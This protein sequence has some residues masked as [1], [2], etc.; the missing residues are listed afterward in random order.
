[1]GRDALVT[2]NR[3]LSHRPTPAQHS[4]VLANPGWIRLT[5]RV[6]MFLVGPL[7]L[8]LT[9]SSRSPLPPAA[10]VIAAIVGIGTFG[11]AVWQRPWNG[12]ELFIAD[13][14]GVTFP[15]NDHVRIQIGKA[16]D[17]RWLCVPW[18][19][20]HDI[21]TAKVRGD[22]TSCVAFDVEVTPVEMNDFF[23]NVGEPSDRASPSGTMVHAAF[24]I[25]PP[26]PAKT[27]AALLALRSRSEA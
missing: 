3:V 7:L 10:L 1:V 6:L 15:A 4:L 9:L 2:P 24:D 23:V 17:A 22:A 5:F 20:I 8:Y 26:A 12:F 25:N 16:V 27:V 11:I 21:R 19:N 18:T 13:E 14:G